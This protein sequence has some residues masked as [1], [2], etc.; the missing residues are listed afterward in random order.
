MLL[1]LYTELIDNFAFDHYFEREF[2]NMV[3]EK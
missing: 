1:F 2:R 3:C